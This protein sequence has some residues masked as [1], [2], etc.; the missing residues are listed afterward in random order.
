MQTILKINGLGKTYGWIDKVQAIQDI[1]LSVSPGEVYGILG[2]NGSGK[3]TTLGIILGCLIQTKG[4]YSWFEKGDEASL[5]KRVGSILEKPYFYPNLTCTQNLKLL[6]YAKGIPADT[7][8][9][10]KALEEVDLGSQGK[11]LFEAL[12]LGMKQRLAIA[13]ALLGNPEVLVLDEPTNGLDAQ[14]IAFVRDLI[15]QFTQKGGSV[16]L[17]SHILDEVEKVCTHVA[18]LARGKLLEDGPIGTVLS[19]KTNFELACDDHSALLSAIQGLT[20]VKTVDDLGT[21]LRVV[22][23]DNISATELHKALIDKGVVLSKLNHQK[24]SLESHF[25]ELLKREDS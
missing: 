20:F 15:N 5:L 7:A 24:S 22:S 25:L 4:Q 17:A 16:L 8:T 23:E 11:T 21:E 14:G 3:T 2:P 18:I 1:N 6:C 13:G 19:G 9:T 12:S 10:N